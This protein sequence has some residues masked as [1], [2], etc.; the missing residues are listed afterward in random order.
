[1]CSSPLRDSIRAGSCVFRAASSLSKTETLTG[2]TALSIASSAAGGAGE[3]DLCGTLGSIV[4]PGAKE[5]SLGMIGRGDDSSDSSDSSSE[6]P[7]DYTL[8]LRSTQ[9]KAKV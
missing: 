7:G 2:S 5:E 9:E 6:D 4:N 8:T 3:D 1:M